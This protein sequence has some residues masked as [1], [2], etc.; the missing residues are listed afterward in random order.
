LTA[1]FII[2]VMLTGA[3]GALVKEL[4]EEMFALK[5]ALY[6]LLRS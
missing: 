6:S 3:P 5:R 4:K 2:R 1:V